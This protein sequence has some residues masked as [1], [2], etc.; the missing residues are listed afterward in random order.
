M[1]KN[2]K[3][4]V[5]YPYPPERVWQ[6]LTDRCALATWM[7]DNDFEPKLGHKFQFRNQL[8]SGNTTIQCE[9][10]E[11]EKPNRLVYTWQ[12]SLTSE[13]ALVIWTLT[14]VTGG[15]QLQL[16]HQEY[17]HTNAITQ[18][19]FGVAKPAYGITFSASMLKFENLVSSSDSN[20]LFNAVNSTNSS[21]AATIVPNTYQRWDYYLKQKLPNIL[22]NHEDSDVTAIPRLTN[23]S[24]LVNHAQD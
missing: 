2:L 1:S 15:T 9:V 10:L 19:S 3:L 23:L 7:M 22:L 4:E 24:Y 17:S 16:K 18:V 13:P 20:I 8:L 6:V 12:D 11:L 5:F 14:P 21:L